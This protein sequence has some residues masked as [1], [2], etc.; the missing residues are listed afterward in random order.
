MRSRFSAVLLVT[1]ILRRIMRAQ[2]KI[3]LDRPPRLKDFLKLNIISPELR[4]TY[5][6]TIQTDTKSTDLENT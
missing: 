3:K 1:E 5:L 4:Q 2:Y 6:H